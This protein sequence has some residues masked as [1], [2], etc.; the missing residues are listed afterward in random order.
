MVVA[1]EAARTTIMD[2]YYKV[3]FNKG[4]AAYRIFV[5]SHLDRRIRP[6]VGYVDCGMTPVSLI[7]LQTW[8]DLREAKKN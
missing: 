7:R 8:T 4:A 5:E 6:R 1:R 3:S 2:S